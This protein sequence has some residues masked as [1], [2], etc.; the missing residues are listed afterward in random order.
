MTFNGSISIS[1]Y[2]ALFEIEKP[3]NDVGRLES[4]S[5]LMVM[6]SG[7]LCPIDDCKWCLDS[8]KIAINSESQL[9]PNEYPMCQDFMQP[10]IKEK[11]TIFQVTVDRIEVSLDFRLQTGLEELK[12]KASPNTTLI[13]ELESLTSKDTCWDSVK[14]FLDF[15]FPASLPLT[16]DNP[17]FVKELVLKA[18]ISKDFVNQVQRY[19]TFL[20]N[21]PGRVGKGKSQNVV[22]ERCKT[23]DWIVQ[24]CLF[25]E[26]FRFETLDVKK[27]VQDLETQLMT[28]FKSWTKKSRKYALF[29]PEVSKNNEMLV[30][31]IGSRFI[32]SMDYLKDNNPFEATFVF[33]K[34]ISTLGWRNVPS[35]MPAPGHLIFWMEF[36]FTITW[37]FIGNSLSP[38][39]DKTSKTSF[40]LSNSLLANVQLVNA[41]LGEMEN[42]E[43]LD[44]IQRLIVKYSGGKSRRLFVRQEH[45]CNFLVG[46]NE[47]SNF[48]LIG[49]FN[50]LCSGSQ[51]QYQLGE[52]ILILSL[53]V[54][55]NIPNNFVDSKY[56]LPIRREIYKIE[57][58]GSIPAQL[59]LLINS[60]NK[61]SGY[62]EVAIALANYAHTRP[63]RRMFQ[64]QW[65]TRESC[66]MTWEEL[67][68]Y[69]VISLSPADLMELALT[70]VNNLDQKQ[71]P[72][73]VNKDIDE[74]DIEKLEAKK[75]IAE[76]EKLKISAIKKIIPVLRQLVMKTYLKKKLFR[77]Y[78]LKEMFW[79][80]SL[81]ENFCGICGVVLGTE[82]GQQL[83]D[84][85][86]PTVLTKELHTKDESHQVAERELQAFKSI[87][88]TEIYEQL[89]KI[90]RF[91][92]QRKVN[93][94]TQIYEDIELDVAKVSASLNTFK[95]T[96]NG[97]ISKRNW[98][99][100]RSVMDAFRALSEDF[101]EKQPKI[102]A[103]FNKAM[104]KGEE[105]EKIEGGVA[106]LDTANN[107]E[108]DPLE[109]EVPDEN[110]LNHQN[111][112]SDKPRG[113]GRG[114]PWYND[115]QGKYPRPS[116]NNRQNRWRD[117]GNYHYP[118]NYSY[119][120]N[121]GY[122]NGYQGGYHQQERYDDYGYR[123][124]YSNRRQYSS[125]RNNRQDGSGGDYNDRGNW[126]RP[127]R[128]SNNGQ[129]YV[130]N[131]RQEFERNLPPRFMKQFINQ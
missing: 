9:V 97:V 69:P 109:V 103:Q 18:R 89:D 43:P 93:E 20:W 82:M 112:R 78:E 31:T 30:E 76:L 11:T 1:I 80:F 60:V 14:N 107:T 123:A 46:H 65:Q 56:E 64:C 48:S 128:N 34:M 72:D 45:L 68:V 117:Q 85:D 41:I 99:D 70:S 12:E 75:K 61:A 71:E 36:Y 79:G 27:N 28:N 35:L 7:R 25:S 91:L 47:F 62:H 38:P 51:P 95:T 77:T 131:N 16:R 44:K 105:A 98:A 24:A 19:L 26:L 88:S 124:E 110:H 111:T 6:K 119:E 96:L 49:L 73:V 53:C 10:S 90:E 106:S 37:F 22:K 63:G 42:K 130:N 3:P 2:V 55:L 121:Q 92:L 23:S 83:E 113:R 102:E 17:S 13:A 120:Q 86:S 87:Y 29:Y 108:E 125:S 118:P 54:L 52:R 67:T 114:R 104:K 59:A 101:K 50:I 58:N 127:G 4:F 115:N 40:Y 8:L 21:N 116:W 84:G 66:P 100:R 32:E 57:L 5:A 122:Y 81:T 74:N 39:K 129:R 126:H 15:V 94:K 33:S